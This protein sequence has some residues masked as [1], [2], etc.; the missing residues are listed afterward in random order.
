MLWCSGLRIQLQWLRSLW[1]RG[2]DPTTRAVSQRIQHCC[3]CGIGQSCSSCSIP[4]LGTSTYLEC[5]VIKKRVEWAEELNRHFSEEEIQMANRYE[6]VLNSI[7]TKAYKSNH[8]EIS[9]HTCWN[10]YHKNYKR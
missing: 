5:V 7:I 3:S 1:R 2:F 6:K 8:N 9:P 4:V 10:G